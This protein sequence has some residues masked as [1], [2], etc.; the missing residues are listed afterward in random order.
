[1]SEHL[2]CEAPLEDHSEGPVKPHP[3]EEE[4]PWEHALM[5][6]HHIGL[7]DPNFPDEERKKEIRVKLGIECREGDWDCLTVKEMEAAGL[8]C[9]KGDVECENERMKIWTGMERKKM[10]ENGFG[11]CGEKDEE[12]WEDMTIAWNENKGGLWV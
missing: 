4:I 7:P 3:V 6:A 12:C 2:E 10:K 8:F 5:E 9:P 11:G 1:M